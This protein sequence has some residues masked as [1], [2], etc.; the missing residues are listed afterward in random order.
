MSIVTEFTAVAKE[1]AI[2]AAAIVPT[3]LAIGLSLDW[4]RSHSPNRP[5]DETQENML[6]KK[7][8]LTP[9]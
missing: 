6:S 7:E 8:S 4:M 3:T 9:R 5:T 1:F 2:L